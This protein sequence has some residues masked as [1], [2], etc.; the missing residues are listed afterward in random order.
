MSTEL[1]WK[2]IYDDGA[3]LPQYNEDASENKYTD[4]DRNK[5][6]RFDL[7]RKDSG[8]VIYSAHLQEGQNLIYRKRTLIEVTMGKDGGEK[9][10]IVYIV[11][12]RRSIMTNSGPKDI[13]A[14]NYIHEDGS[15]AL[16]GARNNLEL[17]GH[18]RS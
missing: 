6:V 1:T 3:E 17:L 11:G 2:A 14:I 16:D 9:R 12:W 18:E 15:V 10:V 4:I 8:R 5:L 13:K 7:L